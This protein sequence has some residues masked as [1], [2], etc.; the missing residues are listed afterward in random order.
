MKDQRL[1]RADV[2]RHQP[3]LAKSLVELERA[4]AEAGIESELVHLIKLR[5]SQLNGCA[6]C[7]RMHNQEA[8]EDGEQQSRLDVL[9]AWRETQL[10]SRR[11]QAALAWTEA[12]TLVSGQEIG[13]GDYTRLAAEFTPEEQVNVTALVVSINA[14]NRIA[15]AFAFPVE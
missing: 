9:S 1:T 11:E 4:V 5:A 10:F 3:M 7:L 15:L 14:W 12:L 13:G 2:F 8:R 6:F